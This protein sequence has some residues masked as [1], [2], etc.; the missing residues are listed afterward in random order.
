MSLLAQPT[1]KN[2][3]NKNNMF[4]KIRMRSQWIV[5][6]CFVTLSLSAFASI[7]ITG[8]R[9]IFPSDKKEVSVLLHNA[10]RTVLVQPWIDLYHG[11]NDENIPFLVTPPLF[12]MEVGQQ[13]VIR[14]LKIREDFAE[15]RESLYWFNVQEIPQTTKAKNVLQLA[16]TT[17]LKLFLRPA[18]LAAPSHDD[19]KKIIWKRVYHQEKWGVQANNPTPYFITL[20]SL[21]LNDRDDLIAKEIVPPFGSAVYMLDKGALLPSANSVSYQTINDYGLPSQAISTLLA[22]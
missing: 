13:A 10:E 7:Q 2:N 16:I 15:D 14:I 9:V 20:Y 19:Y 4:L 18:Q 1:Y 6:C 11:N 8:T 21:R 3:I 12:R 17:R 5:L 22:D